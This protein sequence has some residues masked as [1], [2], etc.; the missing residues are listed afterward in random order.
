[1]A[2]VAPATVVNSS[3][4]Y[5]TTQD[6]EKGASVIFGGEQRQPWKVVNA[7][8]ELRHDL[9]VV[10]LLQVRTMGTCLGSAI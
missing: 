3:D 10:A 7:W 8:L 5:S 9:A 2:P 6:T 4:D 1:M